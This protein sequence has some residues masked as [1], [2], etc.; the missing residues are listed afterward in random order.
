[1]SKKKD[2]R[3]HLFKIKQK[4]SEECTEEINNFSVD[5][6]FQEKVLREYQHM[7]DL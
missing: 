1:M 2:A 7:I 6:K 5:K 3:E 4:R